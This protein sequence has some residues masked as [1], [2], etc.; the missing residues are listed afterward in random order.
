M[1][2]DLLARVEQ[3]KGA[4]DA[5]RLA[6]L[7]EEHTILHNRMQH[8]LDKLHAIVASP[9]PHTMGRAFFSR[10]YNGKSL[11]TKHFLSL[12]PPDLNPLGDAAI[13]KVVRISMPGAASVRELAIR[14]LLAVEEPFSHRWPT[15]HLESAAYAVLR[16]LQCKLLIIDE[17][18][19]MSN[20]SH[21]NTE[22]VKNVVKSIGEDCGCGVALFGTP[23]GLEVLASDPQLERRF[24]HEIIEPWLANKDTMILL[25]NLEARL[26]LRKASG[27]ASDP[28]VVI[29]IVELGDGVI[30]QMRALV[31]KA[32]RTAIQTGREV[33]DLK[34]IEAS[35]WVPFAQRAET[36]ANRLGASNREC[37]IDDGDK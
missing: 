11:L 35:D 32:A 24:E 16:S 27:M 33:I 37:G 31:H 6:F 30:G 7:A 25:H 8:A 2:G 13:V 10:S 4:D 15:S 14:I 18:Q 1:T 3:L 17:F 21:R 23:K 19:D 29:K 5:T 34:T 22:A 12:Y 9:A 36:S 28:K 20:G 26:P